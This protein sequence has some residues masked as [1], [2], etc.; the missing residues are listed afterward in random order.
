MKYALPALA[1]LCLSCSANART[2]EET[3]AAA[4][5]AAPVWDG[6]N[7][8]PGQLRWRYGNVIAEF[9]FTDT[10][11]TGDGGGSMMNTDLLRLRQGHVG[12]QFW[13]IF[14]SASTPGP[15]AV[16]AAIEQIDVTKRLI[17]QNADAMALALTADQ[18]EAAMAEGKIA[19]LLGVEGG[20]M[21][22]NSLAVLRQF[23]E[24]GVRY[25][26]LT[27][28]RNTQWADSA[29]EDPAH[30][31][32]TDFGRQVVREMNRLGMLVDLAHVSE[33]T[34]L[35]ALEESRAPIIFSHSNARSVTQESRNVPDNV[36]DLVPVNG[37][38]VMVTFV[39][40][41]VSTTRNIWLADQAAETARQQWLW[42]GQPGKVAQAMA[43][44]LR[45]HP[46]PVASVAEV[47]D[48]ID[49]LRGRIGIDH[50]GVGGD[51][52]GWPSLVA[53][54]EDVSGYPALFTELARRG[55]SQNDLEKIA[56]RNMMRVMRAAEAYAASQAGMPPIETPAG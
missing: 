18:V 42:Q 13:S 4:L 53:G 29:D 27:H 31:G 49:Y 50:I 16:Q 52:D 36:L 15:E 21:I 32:L 22:N 20:H 54:M 9:D 38:I 30:D 55:Y 26:T 1:A 45:D 25:V 14:T 11:S 10:R 23:D 19:S 8:T 51:Y 6:H 28:S 33:G 48:H 35:D 40:G 41:F 24:L 47:A 37:G 44:W 12:A 56:S 5:D 3:A 34:M 7:D 17:A 46:E 2:A 39:G 43:E